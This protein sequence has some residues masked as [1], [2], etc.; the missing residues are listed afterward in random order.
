MTAESI[1]ESGTAVCGGI[2]SRKSGTAISDSPKPSVDRT[3]DAK[4]LMSRTNSMVIV[5]YVED[6]IVCLDKH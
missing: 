5:M 6:S 1:T 4:K 3:K 2:N